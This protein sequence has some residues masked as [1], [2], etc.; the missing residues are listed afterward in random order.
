M[1]MIYALLPL[2]LLVLSA[3]STI[4]D[5]TKDQL[6]KPVSCETADED[7]ATLTAAIPSNLQR[8]R[9]AIRSVVPVA[10]ATGIVTRDYRDRARV[11]V[12]LHERDLNTKIADI[13]EECG[14]GEGEEE[15]QPASPADTAVEA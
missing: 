3:C 2:S 13:Y 15:P 6:A 8:T 1:R 7:I 14:E 10:A 4:E 12:G 9:A 11:A 5:S